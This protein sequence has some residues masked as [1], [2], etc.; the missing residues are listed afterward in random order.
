MVCVRGGGVGKR[1]IDDGGML[2]KPACKGVDV[3]CEACVEGFVEHKEDWEASADGSCDVR[4]G[5]GNGA[6]LR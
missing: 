5:G 3:S 6:W 1:C 4:A 2:G